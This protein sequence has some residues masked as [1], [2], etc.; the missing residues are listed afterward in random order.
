MPTDPDIE[1]LKEMQAALVDKAMK[2][3]ELKDGEQIMREAAKL[4]EEG[5]K[6]EAACLEVA[7]KK[8][9]EYDALRE[10]YGVPKDKKPRVIKVELTDEQRKR[11]L[12]ETGVRMEVVELEEGTDIPAE[13]WMPQEHP[14]QVEAIARRKALKGQKQK[15]AQEAA[16]QEVADAMAA[17]EAAVQTRDQEQL[18]NELKKDPNFIANQLK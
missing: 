6:L 2:L 18:L 16:K 1:K 9:A 13:K 3:A 12:E 10:K 14:Q 8:E 4:Q 7:A 15:E 5:K 17:V 11:I